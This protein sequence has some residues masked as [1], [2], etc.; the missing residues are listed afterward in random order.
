MKIGIDDPG[1]MPMGD[2]GEVEG[3]DD[4]DGAL[5]GTGADPPPELPPAGGAPV[6]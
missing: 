2:E 5:P 4:G 1:L 6:L 3:M